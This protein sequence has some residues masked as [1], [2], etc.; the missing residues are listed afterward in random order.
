MPVNSRN[1][2]LNNHIVPPNIPTSP[3]T[4]VESSA[5]DTLFEAAQVTGTEYNGNIETP[6]VSGKPPLEKPP[7]DLERSISRMDLLSQEEEIS[8]PRHSL[9]GGTLAGSEQNQSLSGTTLEGSDIVE[10]SVKGR[11]WFMIDSV[12]D[13][14]REDYASI[15]SNDEDIGS[16]SGSRGRGRSELYAVKAFGSIFAKWSELRPQHEAVILG[17][18]PNRFVR[19]YRRI[20]KLHLLKLRRFPETRTYIELIAIRILQSRRNREDIARNVLEALYPKKEEATPFN[21]LSLDRVEKEGIS[22]WLRPFEPPR[23]QDNDGNE[24]DDP[25][26]PGEEESEE[27]SEE[28]NEEGNEE[29]SEDKSVSDHHDDLYSKI[30]SAMDAIS[31][32][33]RSEQTVLQVE[34]HLLI[35]PLS[36]RDILESVPKKDMR[37][38][39]NNGSS[40]LNGFKAL[41]E[42]NTLIEWDWWP[43]RPRMLELP[44]GSKRLEWHVSISLK[45]CNERIL[46]I[47]R[48]LDELILK[49]LLPWKALRCKR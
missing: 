27:E 11:E 26:D 38:T 25:E 35:L 45:L 10:S 5:S 8:E 16:T 6:V 7:G 18:G 33:L 29:E 21:P 40:F 44:T 22:Q 24:R 23:T 43:L 1:C 39:S 19:N 46:K 42:D 41:V 12:L 20:L 31:H 15:F 48:S 36:M 32:F 13:D 37:I 34:L 9:D 17:L 14:T 30:P 4:P 3:E 28:G 2:P 47:N 49:S